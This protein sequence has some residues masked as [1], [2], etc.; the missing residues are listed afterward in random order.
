MNEMLSSGLLALLKVAELS[1][2]TLAAR[3]LHL[4]QPAVSKQLRALEHALGTALVARSGRGIQL[5]AAGRVLAD[6]G[7]RGAALLEEGTRALLELSA[8]DGGQLV[9]G[10]GATTCIFQLP[11]WLGKLRR[12]RPRV[13]V[14]VRTGTSQVVEAM[15]LE[16]EVELG[17]V[18]TPATHRALQQR[19]LFHEAIVLVA[20]R[21][22][23]LA[24]PELESLPLIVF[25]AS[26]GFRAYLD[27]KLGQQRLARAVKM[28]TDSV[29]AIKSFVASGLGVSFLPASAVKHELATRSLRRIALPGLPAL[30]RSTSV[31][32]RRDRPPSAA[33]A[34]FFA[35]LET[36][37]R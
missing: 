15:V 12:E 2:V 8:E 35:I 36:A 19:L 26:T 17:L 28:E 20:G 23:R 5:T 14:T 16:R 31:L 37:A 10:A 11:A 27:S 18:T 24:A 4:S 21:E 7:K 30:R 29:E 34:S 1:S 32:C 25:P 9:L 33:A 3:A 6:Y 22:F 13:D